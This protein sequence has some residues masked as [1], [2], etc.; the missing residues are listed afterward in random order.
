MPISVCSNEEQETQVNVLKQEIKRLEALVKQYQDAGQ[1]IVKGMSFFE[2]SSVQS[3]D[4]EKKELPFDHECSV[5]ERLRT[6]I[7]TNGGYEKM[8]HLTGINSRTLKRAALG[9]TDPKLSIV[10]AI[11]E[12][13]GVSLS[14]LVLGE[15][16]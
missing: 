1:M 7:L 10:V 9:D 14:E 3:I 6:V 5:S 11:S 4:T 15:H 13:S 2:I 16:S 12:V 8:S